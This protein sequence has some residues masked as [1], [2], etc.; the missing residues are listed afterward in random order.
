MNGVVSS[1]PPPVVP[2]VERRSLPASLKPIIAGTPRPG[3]TPSGSAPSVGSRPPDP[4]GTTRGGTA[5]HAISAAPGANRKWFDDRLL[6]MPTTG[7]SPGC[8]RRS[9]SDL[10]IAIRVCVS[11]GELLS[12]N[13]RADNQDRSHDTAPPH[14]VP[15]TLPF[16]ANYSPWW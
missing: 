7:F 1:L 10:S 13:D 2:V 6:R 14:S 8:C 16:G 12:D 11:I 5:A 3:A 4:D 9:I 15:S